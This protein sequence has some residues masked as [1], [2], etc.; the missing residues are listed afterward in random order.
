MSVE[1]SKA[2]TAFVKD[3]SKSGENYFEYKPATCIQEIFNTPLESLIFPKRPISCEADV[4]ELFEQEFPASH[5]LL[6][7]VRVISEYRY[8]SPRVL[9]RVDVAAP[10]KEW[11]QCANKDNCDEVFNLIKERGRVRKGSDVSFPYALLS[12][13]DEHGCYLRYSKSRDVEEIVY[14]PKVLQRRKNR[15]KREQ[16]VRNRKTC[17]TVYEMKSPA[18]AAERILSTWLDVSAWGNDKWSRDTTA[19]LLRQWITIFNLVFG[20]SAHRQLSEFQDLLKLWRIPAIRK[21]TVA[22]WNP[23]S[24]R[25]LSILWAWLDSEAAIPKP[26]KRKFKLSR[27]LATTPSLIHQFNNISPSAYNSVLATKDL[28]RVWCSGKSR[29]ICGKLQNVTPQKIEIKGHTISWC[30][31][32]LIK[33]YPTDPETKRSMGGR[34]LYDCDKHHVESVTVADL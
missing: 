16:D 5:R 20:K 27:N 6:S 28:V 22:A 21:A 31:I 8:Q 3:S 34:L 23:S 25:N 26:R 30:D 29:A 12:K 17:I 32:K 19:I 33:R 4:R 7:R 9:D 13:L 18:M 24:W 11:L 14:D 1:F 2:I 10:D 15:K